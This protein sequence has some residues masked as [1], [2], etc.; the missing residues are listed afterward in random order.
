VI[1]ASECPNV[2]DLTVTSKT[3]SGFIIAFRL[4]E[5]QCMCQFNNIITDS[6]PWA[7]NLYMAKCQPY[8]LLRPGLRATGGKNNSKWYTKLY[9]LFCNYYGIHTVYKCCCGLEVGDPC[10][11]LT[12]SSCSEQVAVVI[13][14]ASFILVCYRYLIWISVVLLAVVTRKFSWFYPVNAF[15]YTTTSS[16]SLNVRHSWSTS[17]HISY[18]VTFIVATVNQFMF[19]S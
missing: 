11:R 4:H 8:P 18:C 12:V 7:S 1:V 15:S 16:R 2:F 10:C 17:D 14:L 5:V 19:C 9:K 3:I 6:R 13:T